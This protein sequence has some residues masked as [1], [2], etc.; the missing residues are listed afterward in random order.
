MMIPGLITL[1]AIALV[2]ACSVGAMPVSEWNKMGVSQPSLSVNQD[3]HEAV[4]TNSPH[5][6]TLASRWI[7]CGAIEYKGYDGCVGEEGN[8]WTCDDGARIYVIKK[9]CTSSHAAQAKLLERL[10]AEDKEHEP[11]RI[12]HTES[13]GAA[14]VVELAEPVSP[15]T[16]EA[17]S[18]KWV[19]I[20]VRDTSLLLIYGPDREHVMD[21]YQTHYAGDA[22]K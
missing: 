14:T 20:W 1:R 21:Y 8:V 2:L 18:S 15:R 9:G 12:T 19:I 4:A 3:G 7:A 22:R 6:Y 10:Q 5:H 17:G 16:K 11:W 13:L